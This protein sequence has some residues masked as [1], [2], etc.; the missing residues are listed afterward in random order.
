MALLHLVYVLLL[1]LLALPSLGSIGD[2]S[3]D[4]VNCVESCTQRNCSGEEGEK[5]GLSLVLR[6]LFWTCSENCE[7][8]CMHEVTRE[9][10]RRGRA[11]RQ[12][13][14]KVSQY[15][16]EA[17]LTSPAHGPSEHDVVV[18]LDSCA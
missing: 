6:V 4:F 13:R 9:D 1:M 18:S 16:P 11:V 17:L 12:F 3:P 5:A 14:G 7:Y 8:E 2:R 15:V 10:V